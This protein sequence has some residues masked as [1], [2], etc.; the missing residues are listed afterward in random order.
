M[1]Q[2]IDW[3]AITAIAAWVE[4]LIFFIPAI[5]IYIRSKIRYVEFWIS[6]KTTNGLKIGIHNKSKYSLYMLREKIEI[7]GKS[8]ISPRHYFKDLDYI[9]EPLRIEPDATIFINIDYEI[10]Q[11]LSSDKIILY[12]KFGGKIKEK[13]K[14]IKRGK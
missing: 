5:L 8:N 10:Y 2:N 13:S 3:N 14:V 6:E 12:V 7:K 4:I 11:I 1:L 9:G